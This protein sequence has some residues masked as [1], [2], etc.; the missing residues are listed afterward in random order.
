MNNMNMFIFSLLIACSLFGISRIVCK[1]IYKH[2]MSKKRRR[3]LISKRTRASHKLDSQFYSTPSFDFS[4]MQCEAEM[5][6]L[7]SG[8]DLCQK[9]GEIKVKH[10]CKY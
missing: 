8:P 3:I 4:N 7:N 2:E 9:R 6:I 10:Y 5:R 1:I